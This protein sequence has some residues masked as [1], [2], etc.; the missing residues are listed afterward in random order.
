MD[1]AN[2]AFEQ[3]IR[4]V[5]RAVVLKGQKPTPA[6]VILLS[7]I[8]NC[9][10]LEEVFKDED[11]LID[12]IKVAKDILKAGAVDNEVKTVLEQ[13]KQYFAAIQ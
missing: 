13:L 3:E 12:A 9:R 1:N 4:D 8:S 5:L 10:I 7:M 11:E 2:Y 6:V